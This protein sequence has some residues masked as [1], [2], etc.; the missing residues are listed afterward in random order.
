MNCHYLLTCFRYQMAVHVYQLPLP[1]KLFRYQMAVHVYQ[2][3]LPCYLC[4]KWQPMYIN[5]HC[6][7]T[8]VGYQRAV[9]VYQLPLPCY[10]C[11]VSNGSPCIATAIA[12]LLVLGIKWQPLYINCSCHVNCVG[13]QMAAHVYQMPLLRYMCF[14]IKWQSI[15]SICH[16]RV[17]CVRY[18]TAVHVYQLPLPYKLFHVSN[19]RPCISSPTVISLFRYQM[20]AHVYHLPLAYN[21]S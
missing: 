10:L 19:G 12:M 1:F 4:I 7:V 14:G 17:N 9:H 2:L 3:P 13:Y 5:C 11:C 16:C 6:H 20:A 15:Y 21:L 8:R 18:R